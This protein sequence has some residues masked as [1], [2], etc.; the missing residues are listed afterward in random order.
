MWRLA[1]ILVLVAGC[2]VGTGDPSSSSDPTANPIDGGLESG[3]EIDG[4][5]LDAERG[6]CFGGVGGA[7]R[8]AGSPCDAMLGET[9][10][11]ATSGC[12]LSY[13]QDDAGALTFRSCFPIDARSTA[14]GTCEALAAADC[15]TRADC[16]SVYT[17]TSI[18]SSFVRCQTRL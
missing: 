13:T 18:F 9:A 15:V 17:G 6:A 11:A 8:C 1:C 2:D 3:G 14:A 12:I 7:I 10:C 16:D 5:Y 4:T